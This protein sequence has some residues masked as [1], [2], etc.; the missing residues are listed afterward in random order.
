MIHKSEVQVVLLSQ[1][2]I[3][4][5]NEKLKNQILALKDDILIMNKDHEQEKEQIRM[6]SAKESDF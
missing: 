4:E 3:R 1:K 6:S 2:E 5:Q